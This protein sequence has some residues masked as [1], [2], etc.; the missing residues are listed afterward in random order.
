MATAEPLILGGCTPNPL[1]SYL[2]ALGVLRL[3]S[4]H[5]SHASGCA[6]DP[7]A[8]GWW[9]NEYFHVKTMFDRDELIDFFLD[10]YAPSPIIA[11]WNGGSG[12]YPKDNK[13]GFA[14][15]TAEVVAKRFVPIADAIRIAS[16][17][18]AQQ[19]LTRQPEKGTKIELV[20]ALRA[21]L[22][23]PAI[24]WIDAV[25]ALSGESLS[26]P[27]LLG[28][29]GNDGRLDFT[30]NFLRRLV[31]KK[32]PLGVFDAASGRPSDRARSLLSSALFDTPS[33]GLDSSAIGQ[34]APGAA[35]GPNATAGYKADGN[36][37]PWDFVLMLEGA[38][39][40]AGAATRR[41]QGRA[42]S[43]ASFPFTVR[44]VGAGW[45]GIEATDE[46]D[47]RAEFWA[48][49]WRRP[50]RFLELDAL[51]A[52]GRGVLTGRTARDGLDFARAAA[53]LGVSRG[54]SEFERY[55]FLMRA[56]K[57][58]LAAPVGRRSASPSL[59]ARLVAD[60]DANGWLDRVRR[61]GRSDAEPAAARNAIKRFEDALFALI[62][63]G[64]PRGRVEQALVAL[65]DVCKWLAASR[66]GREAVGTPPPVL[67]AD[68][69]RMADDGSAEF[70]VAAAL[71]GLGLSP[72]EHGDGAGTEATAENRGAKD[73]GGETGED[74]RALRRKAPPMA[75]HLAPIDEE[76]FFD[77]P[78]LRRRRAWSTGEVPPTVVWSAG[79]L[80]VN[81]TAA[82]QRRLVEAATRRLGDKPF[83]GVAP[84]RLD[85][86][87]TF[88]SA[89][90]DDVRCAALLAGMVWARPTRLPMRR[91][92]DAE[93]GLAFL[94]FAYAV[95]KPLFAPDRTLHRIGALAET[96]RLPIPPGLVARLRAGGGRDDG[97]VTD[98]AVRTALARA[99]GSG[100][101]SPFDPARA[102]GR[103]TGSQGGSIGAG[104]RADRLAASL[105]IPI[106]GEALK[107]LVRR[108][109]PDVL[110]DGNDDATAEDT[111]N[112]A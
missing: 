34:F 46:N 92:G 59:A 55:G 110:T 57:A 11:P 77:G 32:R 29:G 3:I 97:R 102:G 9:E 68:W 48:P 35:G 93:M 6:A 108:A 99:R 100:L 107:I 94:P 40:F 13:D 71:A 91:S 20:A 65:G 72:V 16:S 7:G 56:G 15:L 18:I 8:R 101:P 69:I 37:N 17:A 76:R 44:A 80:V 64:A 22:P 67:S 42:E 75:A 87:A 12:F 83:A 43:G 79:N 96:A 54:F 103:R 86:I 78:H 95:L 106:D 88:L 52:E 19:G 5:A 24:H 90:F 98:D 31:S 2:K 51:L 30:N 14:P 39:A 38:V 105:L 73:G 81:M 41:H 58:Y 33:K 61:V 49:L 89:E 28:S 112:A 45:G 10:D 27:Q 47:A 25:L 85:H 1:A 82:L 104:L 84:A 60:L 66:K 111:K 4:S 23:D 63:P 50:V 26:Y 62:E 70:G 109:Y 53:S 74:A 21:E 36:V